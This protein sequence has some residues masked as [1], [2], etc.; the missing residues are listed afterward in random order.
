MLICWENP[1]STRRNQEKTNARGGEG[2]G[3]LMQ[4]GEA[5]FVAEVRAHV[6]P[7]QVA[8][9]REKGMEKDTVKHTGWGKKTELGRLLQ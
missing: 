7:Q 9:W 2:F 5:V 6:I 4:G 1:D 8:H 3:Y